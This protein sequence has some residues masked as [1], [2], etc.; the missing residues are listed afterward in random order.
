MHASTNLWKA[1]A[2]SALFLA[3]TGFGQSVP[4]EIKANLDAKIKQLQSWSADPAIVA[5][6]R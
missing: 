1:A 4:P 3:G 2:V 6:R 5:E